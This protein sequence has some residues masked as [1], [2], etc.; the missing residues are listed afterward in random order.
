MEEKKLTDKT[1]S[2]EPCKTVCA[3][4]KSSEGN[5]SKSVSTENKSKID[6]QNTVTSVE[7]KSDAS[8]EENRESHKSDTVIQ[9]APE[10]NTETIAEDQTPRKSKRI[11]NITKSK[12]KSRTSGRNKA[13]NRNKINSCGKSD[14]IKMKKDSVERMREK[15]IKKARQAVYRET[16]SSSPDLNIPDVKKHKRHRKPANVYRMIYSD[17]SSV[18]VPDNKKST[19]HKK[20]ITKKRKSNIFDSSD[21]SD[22]E[23]ANAR[24]V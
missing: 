21:G 22:A 19:P 17:E 13:N 18:D 1:D 7:N 2:T 12:A 11:A 4:N 3:D 5:G 23:S 10:S 14:I 16:S 8:N 24:C 15:L 20:N 6:H 9:N